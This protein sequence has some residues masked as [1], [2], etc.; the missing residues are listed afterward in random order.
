MNEPQDNLNK[1]ID[2][3]NSDEKVRDLGIKAVK[4]KRYRWLYFLAIVGVILLFII[5]ICISLFA[6]IAYEDGSLRDVISFGCG[7][8][9]VNIAPTD[10]NFPVI[11]KCPDCKNECAP[12]IKIYPNS[13]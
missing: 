2:L 10:C 3:W 1:R 8:V 13:T 5:A 6:Y 12:Q 7:N 9:S 4:I 11:P